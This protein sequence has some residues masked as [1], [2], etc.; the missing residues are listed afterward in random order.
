[1]SV[2]AGILL[3]AVLFVGLA[4][5]RRERKAGCGP[6]GCWKKQ[7]GFGCGACP[8]DGDGAAGGHEKA[9]RPSSA[10]RPPSRRG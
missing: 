10:V 4:L 8:L 1:M 6:G 3:L 7:L 2:I 9:A 5:V